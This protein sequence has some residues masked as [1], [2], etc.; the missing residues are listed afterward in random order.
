MVGWFTAESYDAATKIWKDLSGNNHDTVASRGTPVVKW[1]NTTTSKDQIDGGRGF[2]ERWVEGN[3]NDGL[4]FP[5]SMLNG[6]N[7]DYTIFH[8]SRY[9]S[10]VNQNRIFDGVSA[11]SDEDNW[12][13][14]KIAKPGGL[15]NLTCNLLKYLK[16]SKNYD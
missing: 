14:K 3:T 1:W 9:A 12:Y 6:P 7:E 16:Y 10:E 8:L 4:Q 15:K 11:T 2:V 13:S 5:T